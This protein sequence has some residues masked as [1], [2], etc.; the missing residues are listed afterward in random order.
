MI[1]DAKAKPNLTGSHK[2]IRKSAHIFL[3]IVID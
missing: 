2:K 3:V 1:Y